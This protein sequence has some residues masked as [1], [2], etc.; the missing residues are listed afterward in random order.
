MTQPPFFGSATHFACLVR[1]CA[2]RLA[3]RIAVAPTATCLSPQG[4]S[5]GTSAALFPWLSSRSSVTSY[6]ESSDP[7][8]F[9]VHSAFGALYL[10]FQS[11]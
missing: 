3:S 6:L 9:V 2:G 1:S 7:Q 8:L 11:S 10:R 4:S 5:L